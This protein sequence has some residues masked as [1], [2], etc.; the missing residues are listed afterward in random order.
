M[1]IHSESPLGKVET[2]LLLLLVCID[3]HQT[4]LHL[5]VYPSQS[6]LP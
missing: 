6:L 4:I 5:A 2:V 1:D 3:Q